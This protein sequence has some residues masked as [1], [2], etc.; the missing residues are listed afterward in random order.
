MMNKITV[1]LKDIIDVSF[2]SADRYCLGAKYNRSHKGR[3]TFER[4]LLR[5]AMSMMITIMVTVIGSSQVLNGDKYNYQLFIQNFCGENTPGELIEEWELRIKAAK[6]TN[7]S[8]TN[9]NP[10]SSD[11]TRYSGNGPFCEADDNDNTTWLYD[12]LLFEEDDDGFIDLSYD[13]WENDS[14]DECEG[15][16]FDDGDDFF[17]TDDLL[18]A[19]NLA[20]VNAHGDASSIHYVQGNLSSFGY[21][22]AWRY[23]AGTSSTPL[24][25]GSFS[26][27][28]IPKF[29]VNSSRLRTR[30]SS[31][32]DLV[33]NAISYPMQEVYYKFELTQRAQILISTDNSLRTFDTILELYDAAGNIV[34]VDDDSGTTGDGKGSVISG[35]DINKGTYTVLVK[36]FNV[37]VGGQFQLLV[38]PNYQSGPTYDDKAN[39]LSVV[40]SEAGCLRDTLTTYTAS[41]STVAELGD[42]QCRTTNPDVWLKFVATRNH[43]TID[44]NGIEDF[45]PEWQLVDNA[46]NRLT[47]CI[48]GRRSFITNAGDTYYIRVINAEVDI[49]GDQYFEICITSPPFICPTQSVLHVDANDT[50]DPSDDGLNWSTAFVDLQDALNVSNACDILTY[51]IWIADGIYIPV[52][53]YV[54][55]NDGISDIEGRTFYI[56]DDVR[57]YGGFGGSEFTRESRNWV[58]NETDLRGNFLVS[59]IL[60]LDG[61]SQNGSITS[62]TIIDGLII[63]S[64]GASGSSSSPGTQGGGVYNKNTSATIRNC[65]FE[66]NSAQ[67]GGGAIFNDCSNSNSPLK[68][69]NNVF[70]RNFSPTA[71]S[72]IYNYICLLYTSPSP[73]D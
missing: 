17:S 42:I 8:A 13:V 7:G 30:T 38:L 43:T 24:D 59:H 68:I 33:K 53:T 23:H 40:V 54:I 12:Q 28:P 35:L 26:A 29:H 6:D 44:I 4:H 60:Y 64:N 15:Y 47:N 70:K 63:K 39:A 1:F 14:G 65:F 19:P 56:T 55:D 57:L 58:T 20:D 50:D 5:V 27:L 69:Y 21:E 36:S 31:T 61:D 22:L 52:E 37:G 32:G 67:L 46:G 41:A 62:N 73:R 45:D 49:T 18:I 25:F 71:G 9:L 2:S 34:A 3:R 66:S 51:D 11:C 48:I 72:A 10:V 16:D